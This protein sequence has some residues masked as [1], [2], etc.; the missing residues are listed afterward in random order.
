MLTFFGLSTYVT[1]VKPGIISE[2][3]L[4][5]QLKKLKTMFYVAVVVV[6]E[7]TNTSD[8]TTAL[9]NIAAAHFI[10]VLAITGIY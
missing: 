9:K 7:S 3:N 4:I 8:I 10:I 5:N 6:N 1:S 2:M